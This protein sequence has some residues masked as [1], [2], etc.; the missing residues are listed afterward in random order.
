[1]PDSRSTAAW[2]ISYAACEA[3]RNGT[4]SQHVGDSPHESVLESVLARRDVRYAQLRNAEA[5]CFIAR[6]DRTV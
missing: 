1:V 3:G 4:W 5:G 6:T 2:V